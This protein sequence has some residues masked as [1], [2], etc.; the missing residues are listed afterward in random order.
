MAG[1]HGSS[2]R[3]RLPEQGHRQALAEIHPRLFDSPPSDLFDIICKYRHLT[4]GRDTG[5]IQ[6]LE[7]QVAASTS[8]TTNKVD[9]SGTAPEGYRYKCPSAKCT[10]TYSKG[11]HIV[12]H[13]DTTHPEYLQLHPEWQPSQHIVKADRSLPSSPEIDRRSVR[14]TLEV[15]HEASRH[16]SSTGRPL[17]SD[18]GSTA[19]DFL[20]SVE[21][22]NG[23]PSSWGLKSMSDIEN[24]EPTSFVPSSIEATEENRTSLPQLRRIHYLSSGTRHSS[25]GGL[26]PEPDVMTAKRGR[27][28]FSSSESVTSTFSLTNSC[29]QKPQRRHSKRLSVS[30]SYHY[31]APSWS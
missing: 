17:S 28:P 14:P 4:D 18:C 10:K 9:G 3:L 26:Q 6:R 12:R 21:Y 7:K 23:S 24:N 19:V 1:M 11:G 30:N 16:T 22:L 2:V 20:D 27:D 13:I 5:I 29:A 8:A 15:V 25:Y 31:D